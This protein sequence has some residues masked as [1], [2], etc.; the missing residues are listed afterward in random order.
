MG[1]DRLAVSTV[2]VPEGIALQIHYSTIA[3]SI[4][5]DAADRKFRNMPLTVRKV[6]G[7][8]A[9]ARRAGMA[10]RYDPDVPESPTCS[11]CGRSR[12]CLAVS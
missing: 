2:D 11:I 9:M 10:E 8:A 6:R 5:G 1:L 3:A 4:E 12:S 7:Y